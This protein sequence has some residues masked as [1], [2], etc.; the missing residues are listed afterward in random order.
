MS[1]KI[2]I[3]IISEVSMWRDLGNPAYH[4]VTAI[5]SLNCTYAHVRFA[6]FSV[7]FPSF[8]FSFFALFSTFSKG[9]C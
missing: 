6:L 8:L 9:L 4:F 2:C 3:C 1:C 5:L 7:R